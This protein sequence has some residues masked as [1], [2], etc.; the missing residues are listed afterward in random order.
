MS[1]DVCHEPLSTSSI[2]QRPEVCCVPPNVTNNPDQ[3]CTSHLPSA[4][5]SITA[6]S[7]QEG[8]PNHAEPVQLRECPS[9]ASMHHHIPDYAQQANYMRVDSVRLADGDS[10]LESGVTSGVAV[11]RPET[12]ITCS[13]QY[14]L[15]KQE[16][17]AVMLVGYQSSAV[18]G[19]HGA[20][21]CASLGHTVGSS[22]SCH[23]HSDVSRH[24]FSV[25]T[26]SVQ[27]VQV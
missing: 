26:R 16:N 27:E 5:P 24:I 10:E 19:V 25:S 17:A 6:T 8:L 12:I 14:L 21:L 11:D 7:G 15:Q 3:Q 4:S 22:Q 2:A 13:N 9:V 20:P 23:G 1:L 18:G